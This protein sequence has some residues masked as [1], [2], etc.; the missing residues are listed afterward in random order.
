MM[1]ENGSEFVTA[2]GLAEYLSQEYKESEIVSYNVYGKSDVESDLGREIT[3][4]QWLEFIREWENDDVLNEIRAQSWMLLIDNL[5][6]EM[7]IEE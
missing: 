1:Y 2:G 5:R 6:Q 3:D 4:E 7:G